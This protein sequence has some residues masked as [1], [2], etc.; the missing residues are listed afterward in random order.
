[1]YIYMRMASTLSMHRRAHYNIK[2]T[3]C[4]QYY[5]L[6][7]HII[8]I[9]RYVLNASRRKNAQ[10]TGGVGM[11]RATFAGWMMGECIVSRFVVRSLVRSFVYVCCDLSG[12]LYSCPPRR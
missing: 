9:I 2:H 7:T 11:M 4:Q 10:W 1:M 5:P 8:S 12:R 3:C 6:C